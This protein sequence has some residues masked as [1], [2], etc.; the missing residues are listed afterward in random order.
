[1]F[2]SWSDSGAATHTI[3]ASA[4]AVFIA[5]FGT[6]YWLTT[7]ANPAAGGTVRPVSGWYNAGTG[8][9]V[10]VAANA[11]YQFN[12]FTQGLAGTATPQTVTMTGPT[13]VIASF[14]PIIATSPGSA[15]G[16]A[17][18]KISV[19]RNSNGVLAGTVTLAGAAPSGGAIVSLSSSNTALAKVPSSA[20]VPQGGTSTTFLITAGSA[21][22]G[23][24]TFTITASYG[25]VSKRITITANARA[26]A[27]GR[28]QVP[29]EP[30]PIAGVSGWG[31]RWRDR[32][33]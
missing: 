7:T 1:M 29:S 21:A 32:Q 16:V 11:G 20:T 8:V 15:T 10:S 17:L 19:G 6:Q 2:A 27:S 26:L 25:G 13:T 5:N 22:T 9:S 24:I 14:I 28:R 33:V 31:S 18:S 30:I 4:N 12:G 23:T 3:A